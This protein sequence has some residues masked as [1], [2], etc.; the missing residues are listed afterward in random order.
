[1]E[2]GCQSAVNGTRNRNERIRNG[3]TFF[4]TVSEILEE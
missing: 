3:M 4:V 2:S 1:M